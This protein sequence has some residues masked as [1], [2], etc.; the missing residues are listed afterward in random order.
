MNVGLRLLASFAA[1]LAGV[2]AVVVV[3]VLLHSTV[4]T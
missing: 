1:L 2:I 3:L 4:P